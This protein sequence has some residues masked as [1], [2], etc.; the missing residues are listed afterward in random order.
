MGYANFAV[1]T[2]IA[3]LIIN[4]PR[5]C[6]L[7]I[8]L[9]FTFNVK[10]QTV[11]VKHKSGLDSLLIAIER[12]M[13]QEHMPGLMLSMVTKD[14]IL[15]SGGVGYS[16]LENKIK[17]NSATL[18]HMNS[19]TKMFIALAIQKLMAA[20]KLNLNDELKLIAPEIV[21][22][23]TWE[24]TNP[25]RIVNLLE[26]TA[27]FDDG[28]LNSML[29]RS[30]KTLTG[31]KAV[32]AIETSL[33]SRW[34]PGERMSYSNPD[35]VVLGYLI[36][37]LSGLP[38]NEYVTQN[39]LLPLGMERSTYDLTGKV[40]PQYAKGYYSVGNNY[41][42]FVLA[43]PGDNGAAGALVTNAADVSKFIK[44]LL[45]GWKTAAGQWLPASS[46]DEMET[47]HSTLAAKYG[48]QTGYA[49]ANELFPNNKKITFRGHNGMGEGFNSWI[50]YNR[51]AGIG[52]AICNNGN[53]GMW[54][55][56]QVIE[57]Y[58]TKALKEQKP[59]DSKHN[60]DHL[61]PFTGYYQFTNPRS[62]KI[63]FYEKV[64]NGLTLS[65]V[66][67]KL[68][69]TRK[70][71]TDTLI[72]TGG[73]LF[74]A[75][76]HI[77]PSFVLGKDK[78]GQPFFQGYENGFYQKTPYA[79]VYFQKILI[80]AGI[81]AMILSVVVALVTIVLRAF[82]KTSWIVIIITVLQALG[83]LSLIAAIHKMELT[84][85]I[86]KAA[87]SSVNYTTIYIFLGTLGF[88]LLSLASIYFLFSR[89]S[90]IGNR[91][92]KA[93]LTLNSIFIFYMVCLL[94][95]HGWIGVRIWAL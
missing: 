71:R 93:L 46:L 55:V 68:V 2:F 7:L 19:V 47:V 45:N 53:K 18:F 70:G 17:A 38:W 44:N 9:L 43:T 21:F 80:L 81:V 90:L 84:D 32:E 82:K 49:L 72:N 89:W 35:Y 1:L 67:N 30:G 75:S 10:A 12:T 95:Y 29:N 22:K 85:Q 11:T 87:F 60:L 64:F 27:G 94:F 6:I 26:H 86:N 34:R 20:G 74:R 3:M 39:V 73:N 91:W 24:K 28:H 37:K 78:S 40:N 77:I 16:N 69:V 58:L 8:T 31:L 5:I 36:E 65:I 83:V 48:L 92:F 15:Y 56:S 25:V 62:E 13:K 41:K 4:K 23:N 88:G 50:F 42:P 66:N 61:I 14:S 79:W 51:Q 57:D 63:G 54:A 76:D 59:Q 52:Y 33:T